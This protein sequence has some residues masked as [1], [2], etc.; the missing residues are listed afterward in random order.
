MRRD[1]EHLARGRGRTAATDRQATRAR[2]VAVDEENRALRAA[3]VAVQRERDAALAE[4]AG[5]RELV[6]SLPREGWR[7]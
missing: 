4:L 7:A 1:L 3:L 5:L 2:L 6:D